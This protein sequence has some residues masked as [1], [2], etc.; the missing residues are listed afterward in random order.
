ML[1][2]VIDG[3]GNEQNLIAPGQET[4]TDR[5]GIATGSPQLAMAAS[6]GNR[7]GFLFQNGSLL[8]NDMWINFEGDAAPG[9]PSIRVVPG[10]IVS[11]FNYPVTLSALSVIG[12]AGDGFAAREW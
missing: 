9:A 12:T 4:V 11:S 5:S 1:I 7:S 8:G 2:P 6:V 3:S 10:Q